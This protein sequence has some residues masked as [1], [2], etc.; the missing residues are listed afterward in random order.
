[1]HKWLNLASLINNTPFAL[2]DLG[3]PDG[4]GLDAAKKLRARHN[5]I[6]V[7]I[8]TARDTLKDIVTG[9]D[10]GADDYLIKPFALEELEARIRVI[11]RRNEGRATPVLTWEN[12]QLDPVSH[13]LNIDGSPVILS[14]REFSVLYAL[15]GKPGAVLSRHQLEEKIYGWNQEIES[16]TIEY[17][18]SQIRKKLGKNVIR[19]IRGVGYA[20]KEELDV[21]TPGPFYFSCLAGFCS[22]LLSLLP[23]LILNAPHKR[24][25]S[26]SVTI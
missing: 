21:D 9:L 17:H 26:F 22:A 12:I 8:I 3:L 7:L 25:R 4:S 5:P 15:M 14:G 10:Q 1:M 16:N 6:P 2:L 11:M 20:M 18:I 13:Q 24:C 23:P 19:N